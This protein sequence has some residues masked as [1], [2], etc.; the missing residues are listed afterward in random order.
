MATPSLTP[1]NSAET[2]LWDSSLI[3]R[4][5]LSGP[6]YTSYPTAP[7]FHNLI[8]DQD[9]S[10][11]LAR[12]DNAARP[13]S[14][15]CHIPFCNTVCYYCACNKVIT[16]DKSKSIPYLER[17]FKEMAMMA[18]RIDRHRPVDQLHWGGGTPT[19]LS[20]EQMAALM[21]ETRKHFNL[22]TDDSGE[23]AL[24]IHPASVTPETL[25]GLRALGFNRLSIGIQDFDPAVQKAVNRFNSVEEVSS[26]IKQARNSAYHSISM[27]LIYGLP[28]QSLNSI[29]STLE[30]VIRL[31]PDRLSVFNYAHMPHLF[32]VQK[33]IDETALPSA[34]AKLDMLHYI[35]ERLD[36]EGY[37]YIGMDH[38]AKPGDE[39]ARA[40]A[41]GKL[42]RN[43]QGYATHGHCDL[44]AF[45]VSA[46]S[47]IDNL[48]LQNH[49][50][51]NHYYQA[52]DQ[53]LA[54][55]AKGFAMSQDDHIRK[56][57]IMD[58]ICQFQVTF[59]DIEQAFGIEFKHYF[60]QALVQLISME[61]DGLLRVDNQGIRV[62]A[63]GRLLI[64]RICMAFDAYITPETKQSFSKII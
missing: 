10:G 23:Y 62:L 64:R 50:Q 47:Q 25:K 33:Q 21:Q 41:E 32:K 28:K 42:H 58:L 61:K 43:F 2:A 59:S 6:R 48:Y 4:Y 3:A 56:A 22:H 20:L 5:D 30:A 7:Q 16:A 35:I 44:L 52:L 24:E 14:I 1:A 57:V 54:P 36:N 53:N 37:V 45:G 17:L 31:S 49:K 11:A 8:S 13:L 51:L 26:L 19:Y 27:D 34:N 63:K 15:Y 9:I 12:S 60:K 38:F 39:L 46:I 18:T 29:A 40:Q 55:I